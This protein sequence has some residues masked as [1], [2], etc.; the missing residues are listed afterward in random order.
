MDRGRDAGTALGK[1]IVETAQLI[2]PE[3]SKKNFLDG[4]FVEVKL[5]LGMV[6]RKQK[7]DIK[8]GKE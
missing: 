7:Q 2:Y 1:S 8:L 5:A 3:N 6:I 4:L